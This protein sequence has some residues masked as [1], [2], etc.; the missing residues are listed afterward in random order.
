MSVWKIEEKFQI[1]RRKL[2]R[3]RISAKRP[4]P[5]KSV[6]FL[7]QQKVD[8][9]VSKHLKELQRKNYSGEGAT[10]SPANTNGGESGTDNTNGYR[11]NSRTTNKKPKKGLKKGNATIQESDIFNPYK[12]KKPRPSTKHQF[13]TGRGRGRGKGRKGNGKGRGRG[14]QGHAD[15]N[16]N[17]GRR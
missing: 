17:N 14:R 13:T 15:S 6:N 16:N 9:A 12:G 11:K 10:A 7:V 8:Q 1:R 5:N 3:G 2:I 4:P